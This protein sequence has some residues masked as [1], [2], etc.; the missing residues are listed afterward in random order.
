MRTVERLCSQGAGRL[1]N[2][3]KTGEALEA[4]GVRKVPR[5]KTG[6]EVLLEHRG[7]ESKPQE[8]EVLWKGEGKE[9]DP[10]FIES[11]LNGSH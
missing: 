2:S 6:G 5:K 4:G 7:S 8:V 3:T 10:P 9:T 1:K 11:F